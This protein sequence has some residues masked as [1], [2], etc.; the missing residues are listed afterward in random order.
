MVT[1]RYKDFAN[2][3]INTMK[4]KGH[5]TSRSSHGI[6]IRTLAK[7]AGVSEQICRRYIRGNALPDYE[8]IIDISNF[9]EVSPGWL[10]FGEQN[11]RIKTTST[12]QM[13]DKLLHYLL[14]KSYSLYREQFDNSDDYADF[15]ME[16]ARDIR[17][18]DISLDNLYKIIDIAV[19]SICSY[20]EKYAKKLQVQ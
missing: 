14:K 4:E 13:D 1:D 7:C 16:L 17:K 20:E 10:L 6:C 19:S 9:L 8:K 15:V 2:R 5:A 12:N 18:I 3:L 11:N